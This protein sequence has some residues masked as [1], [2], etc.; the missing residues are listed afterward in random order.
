MN[1]VDKNLSYKFYSST[2]KA[3]EA[4]YRQV[5]G[6]Y[7]SIYWEVYIFIDDQAGSKFVDLLCEKAKQGTDVKIIVDAFGSFGLSQISINRLNNAGAEVI[8]FNPLSPNLLKMRQWWSRV[9]SRTHCKILIIDEEIAF[10]GG[11][12]IQQHMEKWDDL[13]LMLKGEIVNQLLRYFASKYTK[14][15]GSR[16]S[17]RHFFK[18][19]LTK[20]SSKIKFLAHSPRYRYKR[21]PIRRFYKTALLSAKESFNILS[22]Y[23]SPDPR[24]LE[25]IFRASRRGVKVNI[26]LPF[27]ND[28]ILMHYMARAFYGISK[29]AGAIFFF[30]R[31]MNHGKAITSDN[32]LGMVGSANMTPRS[33]FLNHEAGVIFTDTQMVSDLNG[34]LDNWKSQA[35]PLLEMDFKKQGWFKRFK[36][37]WAMRLKDHV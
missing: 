10:I 31:K 34:I 2:L 33:F 12:N 32:N 18:R 9:W 14:A 7:K 13:H 5:L 35:D 26:I 16:K 6:A 4:M 20:E 11:V 8:I 28:L 1:N 19:S 21:S 3:W 15:G 30:L 36:S 25:M 37:W 29:K 17:V 23:Y 27:K 24:F 22:P